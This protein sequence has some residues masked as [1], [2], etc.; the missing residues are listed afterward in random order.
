MLRKSSRTLH[1]DQSQGH[2]MSDSA[3]DS[4]FSSDVLVQKNRISSFSSVPGVFVGFTAKG[5]SDYESANSPTSPL[6]VKA[7]SNLFPF[8]S[9][10]LGQP[11]KRWGCN[12]NKVG[13]GIVDSLNDETE[14]CGTVLGSS[15]SRNILFGSQMRMN[16]PSCQ[17][18]VLKSLDSS[19]TPRSLPK[20]Y[21]ISPLKSPNPQ[22]GSSD[23]VPGSHV[24]K[25]ENEVVGNSRLCLSYYGRSSPL[26]NSLMYC[27]PKSKSDDFQLATRNTQQD[28]GPLPLVRGSTIFEKFS[29]RKSSSLP[30]S[31]G[32]GHEFIGSLPSSEIELS[33]D[34]TCVIS[35]GPNPRTTHIYGD[36]ILE[37]HSVELADCNKEEKWWIGSPQLLKGSDN[38]YPS[39]D[40]LSC[41]Y[42]CKKRLEEGKDIYMYRFDSWLHFPSIAHNAMLMRF[43]SS[44]SAIVLRNENDLNG[45]LFPFL[46]SHTETVFYLRKM[47]GL[48][49]LQE[50]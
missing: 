20:N 18:L 37:S 28:S 8:R 23:K 15:K 7:F 13:L 45:F 43:Q 14:P 31:K 3:S 33:E 26:L 16:I 42:T 38:S 1:K 46:K 50:G 24:I 34:Y 11:Q 27:N 48:K 47:L 35:H 40:F 21:A 29:D 41:C 49:V 22:S 4:S 17:A 12:N 30:V 6:D 44:C 5:I 2:L 10:R 25:F 19:L 36:C 39:D 9:P 32:S